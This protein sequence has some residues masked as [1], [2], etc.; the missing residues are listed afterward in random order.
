MSSPWAMMSK[1][2]LRGFRQAIGSWKIICM[3]MRKRWL[4][5]LESLPE[6]SMPSKEILPAVGSYRRITLRP[7]VDFPEPDSPTSPNTSPG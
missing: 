2:F 7:M 3:P 1:T 4:V 6:T 5:S